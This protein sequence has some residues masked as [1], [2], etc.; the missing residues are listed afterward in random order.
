VPSAI[1]IAAR[2]MADDIFRLNV[3]SQNLANVNTP[4]YKKD[5]V[6]SRPFIEQLQAS[7]AGAQAGL[8]MQG[9]SAQGASM[10]VPLPALSSVP[11]FR[12]GTLTGTGNPLDLAL[13]GGGFFELA[14]ADG[15]VY[16]RAGSFRLD[17]RARLVSPAGLPVMGMGGEISLAGAQPTIDKQGRIFEAGQ[18]AGQLKVV[19]F[20]DPRALEPL[21]GG[22]YRAESRGDVTVEPF[23]VRQGFLESSNVAALPEMVHVMELM[24]R[25]ETAQ[26]IAQSYDGM[27]GGAIQKLG[28]L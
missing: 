24:R 7:A 9:L 3:V 27:L 14:G 20:A 21:G 19:R 17:N 1:S 18:L 28:E 25:F 16:T 15:P 13:E 5:V 23:A 6:S 12:Q 8:A 26:K 22:L 10:Q 11:D 4:G 2:I